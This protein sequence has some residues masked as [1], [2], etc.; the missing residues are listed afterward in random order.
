MIKNEVRCGSLASKYY[1]LKQSKKFR[2]DAKIVIQ[3]QVSNVIDQVEPVA[4]TKQK[5]KQG[6][7]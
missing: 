4:A 5:E 3:A 2:A 7:G 6:N 1:I